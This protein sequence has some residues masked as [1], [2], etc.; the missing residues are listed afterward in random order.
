M[1]NK[2]S[3]KK[4]LKASKNISDGGEHTFSPASK[5]RLSTSESHKQQQAINQYRQKAASRQACREEVLRKLA[6]RDVVVFTLT[7]KQSIQQGSSRRPLD[8][9]LL[10]REVIKTLN[11]L[12]R[13]QLGIRY[14]R[15]RERLDWFFAIER[16]ADGRLHVH[17]ACALPAPAIWDDPVAK[18]ELDLLTQWKKCAWGYH[19]QKI[20]PAFDLAGWIQYCTKNGIDSF[21]Y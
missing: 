5:L 15:H 16:S 14:R 6:G 12:Q 19:E 1:K 21:R 17:G 2:I 3:V 9:D 20:K 11:R 13:A 10:A 4:H 7:C 8:E 18:F